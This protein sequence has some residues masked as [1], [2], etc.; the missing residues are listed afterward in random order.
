MDFTVHVFH[1]FA[2]HDEA[3]PLFKQILSKLEKAMATL[4]DVVAKV[5]ALTTVDDSVVA[6]LGDLKTKLD[7]AIAG[8][9]DPAKLQALSDALGAQ[10]QRLSDAVTSNT[11]AA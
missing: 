2:S 1:H 3:N 4:D 8:G 10:A 7:A 11:P 9:A 6:L 5:A